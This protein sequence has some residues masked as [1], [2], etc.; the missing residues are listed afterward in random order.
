M[1][2]NFF[3]MIM[4]LLAL[5]ACLLVSCGDE[6]EI[7]DNVEK[8]YSCYTKPTNVLILS[9]GIAYNWEHGTDTRYFYDKLFTIDEYNKMSTAEISDK[10]ATGNIED[11]N[12]PDPNNYA[13]HYNLYPD[14]EYVYVTV[15][16]TMDGER[17]ETV[18][19]RF[20]TKSISAQPLAEIIDCAYYTDSNNGTYYGWNI[21]K[22]TYCKEYYT[23]AAA[24]KDI[25]MT[26]SWAAKGATAIYA[27][28]ILEEIKKNP[29]DHSTNINELTNC[30]EY[31]YSAQLNN[32]ISYLPAILGYENYLQIVTWGLSNSG[33]LSGVLDC[34]IYDLQSSSSTSIAR[35]KY[36]KKVVDGKPESVIVNRN[37]LEVFRVK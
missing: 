6:D 36:D 3:S 10:V 35:C 29:S 37:D 16:Y 30:S 32:G 20:K 12:V 11:R 7:K 17:G 14:Y 31:F 15:S 4:P 33:D 9:D 13:C 27:W 25:F 28:A 19:T 8:T 22:N 2:T 21:V 26:L 1:K 23:Y 5:S 18:T 24:C 34:K